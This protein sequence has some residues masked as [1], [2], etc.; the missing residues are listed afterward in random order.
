MQAWKLVLPVSLG[1]RG[2][3][4][5]EIKLRTIKCTNNVLNLIP[6]SKASFLE[7]LIL[8]FLNIQ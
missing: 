7:L 2:M 5:V 3:T 6:F 4:K 1:G 8:I